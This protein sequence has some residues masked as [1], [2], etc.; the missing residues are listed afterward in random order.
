M[1]KQTL[2]D[3]IRDVLCHL[4]DCSRLETNA[5]A[6]TWLQAGINVRA[7]IERAAQILPKRLRTII[8][9][10][11]LDGELHRVV[12]SELGISERYFYRQRREA[13]DRLGRALAITNAPIPMQASEADPVGVRLGYATAL[14]N[15]GCFDAAIG[16][17]EKLEAEIE[18]ESRAR[19]A[20]RLADLC[21]DAGLLDVARTHLNRIKTIVHNVSARGG[22]TA[23]LECQFDVVRARFAR[24]SSDLPSARTIAEV[25]IGRLHGV[26][27]TM[28]SSQVAE[29]LASALLVLMELDREKGAFGAAMSAAL[30]AK[31]VI[32]RALVPEPGLRLRC[33]VAV[34]NVRAFMAGELAH[35][36]DDLAVAYEYAN[37]HALARES[38]R[39]AGM[40]C[41]M[42]QKRGELDRGLAFGVAALPVARSA[43]QVEDFTGLCL[44]VA[45]AHTA[46]HDT[47]SARIILGEAVS[48]C[49]LFRDS[50]SYAITRLIEAE[51]DLLE[52]RYE[53][54]LA[55]ARSGAGIF[56]QLGSD[57]FLGSALRLQAEAHDGLANRRDAIAAIDAAIG[58]LLPSGHAYTL[59]RAY[60]CS[61]RLTG[62]RAHA[63]AEQDLTRMLQA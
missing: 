6:L 31:A 19:V 32:D 12:A 28:M 43:C 53:D 10:C 5:L 55:E 61:A 48:S 11:D 39:I 30:E 62:K 35:A 50:Y 44:D 56:E 36:L 15:A 63:L 59:A 47:R 52:H 21:C 26:S 22:D 34:A 18:G 8:V 38:V 57:R 46:C 33:M 37:V 13:I 25:V 24:L 58:Y 20:C 27:A 17:L 3:Q 45:S 51:I 40:F 4:D 23:L 60:R 14:Q 54:A 41:G 16:A 2:H 42:Y 9:R 1:K 49:K 7:V 29:A